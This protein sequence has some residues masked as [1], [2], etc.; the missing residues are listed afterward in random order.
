M[1]HYLTTCTSCLLLAT[2]FITAAC[3]KAVETNPDVDHINNVAVNDL[4]QYNVHVSTIAGRFGI[5]GDGDGQGGKARFW[6]PTKMVYDNRNHTLYVADGTV[7]RSIDQ[8]NNVKTYLPFGKINNYDEIL[9]MD[10]TKDSIGGSL[11]FY[12]QRKR[13][14]QN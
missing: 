10:V 2:L 6:N 8:Q 7:I 3:S 4:T 12:N 5:Q 13:S 1:R 9:D 11:Y 14:I